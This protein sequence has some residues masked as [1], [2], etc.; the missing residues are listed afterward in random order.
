MCYNKSVDKIVEK[1]ITSQDAQEKLKIFGKNE[2]LSG[3]RAV[4]LFLFL[5]QFPTFINAIL[6]S[7]SL[8]SFVI[9]NIIDGIF[10]ISVL[11]INAIFGFAQEYKA[12]KSLQKLKEYVKTTV[13]AIRNS[14]ETQI[15]T[16]EIV[17]SDLIILS[18]G[19]RIPADGKLRSYKPIEVDESILTGE[20]IPVIKNKND[21]IFLGT[22]ITR[23]RGILIV[24]KTGM[25]TRFGKIAHTL[26]SLTSEKTPFQRR[27]DGLGRTIT[28]TV[29]GITFFLI[30]IGTFQGK[31]FLPLA[32]L[33]ISVGV[34]SIPEGLP[35]I[36]TIALA[37][38][39]SRMA[40]KKAI[41]R[42]MAS[43]ETLGA[44]QIILIDKTGTITQNSQTVKKVWLRSK[45]S[46]SHLLKA[47][48][49]GNT[50]SLI[51]K[52]NSNSFDIVGSKTDG[53]LL[54]FAKE[55]IKDIEK[56]KNNAK[57]IDEFSFDPERKTITTILEEEGKNY[58][59]VRGAPEVILEEAK[60]DNQ[61]KKHI[62]SLIEE[63]ASEGLR[64]IGFGSKLE[65]HSNLQREHLEKDLNFLGI[66]GIYD[67][68]RVEAKAAV[69]KAK[70]AGI[71]VIMVT[72]DNELT[73]LSIAKE[74]GLIDK[75][76]DVVT[77]EEIE[78]MPDE[79]LE[80]IILKTRIFA[81][82]RPEDKLRL[83]NI[84]KKLGLVV[85]V[86]GDG[87]NDALA[88]KKADV[89]ISM[90]EKGTDVAKEASDIVLTDDNFSTL[91]RA[92]EEGRTIYNNIT[93]SVTYLITGNLSEIAL[94]FFGSLLGMPNPLL[95]T[96]ILWINVVTDSV[97]SLALASDN[98]DHEVLKLKPRNPN[99]PILSNHRLIFILGIGLLLAFILLLI[100]KLSLGVYSETFSRTI[101]FNLLVISHMALAFLIRGKSIF[102]M[103]KFLIIGV[104]ITLV[105]Q[106]IVTL[107]PFSQKILSLGF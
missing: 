43:V 53:A 79:E 40:K 35:V 49:F 24:E 74:V 82:N 70:T 84:Y 5:S 20:S 95:P 8:L 63:Y 98:K 86:T 25:Q 7:A 75:D 87:V 52:A 104:V 4:P 48:I 33:A 29:I 58:V 97:P 105:L 13:R 3:E 27:L 9:G 66:V 107:T 45:E 22:L 19:D 59:Y 99:A 94:V 78:K 31:E 28:Y 41:V 51:Q 38:G 101:I 71:R 57:I 15:L 26:T 76:E 62:T 91:V 23:G 103:N 47:C 14:K 6:A 73:A 46:L 96:Q 34:A 36:V 32:I 11:V 90:G 68:P 50:A 89:G 92:V 16:S 72:G 30:L 21:D 81:R 1:G 54:I 55:K 83:V 64:V 39:V 106:V 17:P 65:K 67:P 10:I 44:V 80:K 2:I 56:I 93:K 69:E 85:G 100:F 61:S 102:K 77:G 37:I 18:E 60:V 88:L 12:E 42:K